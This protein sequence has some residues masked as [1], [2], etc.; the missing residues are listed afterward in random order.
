MLNREG[1][2]VTLTGWGRQALNQT[3]RKSHDLWEAQMSI[4]S[5]KYCNS[6]HNISGGD[7]GGL[8][9]KFLPHLFTPEVI[10]AG[11]EV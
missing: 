5:R 3:N 9:D 4:F 8:I 1:E 6:K 10:C 11:S 7:I 2:L